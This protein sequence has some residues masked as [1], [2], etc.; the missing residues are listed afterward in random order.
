MNPI[1]L[2]P[3]I[4]PLEDSNPPDG[5]YFYDN[6][7]KYLI[8]DIIKMES[9]GI[10]INLDKVAEVQNTV[11]TVLD[12]VKDKL[13]TNKLML[14]FLSNKDNIA[15][16][17]KINSLNEKLKTPEDFIKPFNSKNKIHR[18]YVINEFLKETNREDMILEEWSIKD[19]KKLNQIIASNF[20]NNLLDNSIKDYMIPIIDK[21]MY[22][23]ATIKAEIYNKNKIKSKIESLDKVKL[24]D[25]FNPGSSTQKQEFFKFYDI[26]S[27]KETKTGN[28]QWDR[29]ALEEL[30]KLLK[31][32]IEDKE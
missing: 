11:D 4:R 13:A 28:P 2:L 5:T 25:K 8:P 30:Q 31:T 21:A 7:I 3:I 16:Q 6:V 12:N 24:I 19:I 14:E 29:D 27:D 23:L 26:K 15:K 9:N 17:N 22:A 20:I 1:D 18:T 10:P 32:M